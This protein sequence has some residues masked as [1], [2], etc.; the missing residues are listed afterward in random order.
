MYACIQPASSLCAF[1]SARIL[2]NVPAVAAQKALF[3][4]CSLCDTAGLA[5]IFFLYAG[6]HYLSVS[7]L[8]N[9]DTALNENL[10]QKYMYMA[11]ACAAA[12]ALYITPAQWVQGSL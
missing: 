1:L 2:E 12:R 10:F 5:H 11:E 4:L 8:I 3:P 9:K 6:A 7:L